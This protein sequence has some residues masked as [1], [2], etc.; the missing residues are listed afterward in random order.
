L[1]LRPGHLIDFRTV[2]WD[3][4]D[5][6]RWA[7]RYLG[8]DDDGIW[9]GAPAA[10]LRI[11]PNGVVERIERS[12]VRLLPSV[13][14]WCAMWNHL[15]DLDVYVD[16]CA[17]PEW[18]GGSCR[19]RDLQLDVVRY[20]DGTVRT[21]DEDEF[22]AARQRW[23]YSP[24]LVRQALE[25]TRRL[26]TALREATPPFNASPLRWLVITGGLEPAEFAGV[27]D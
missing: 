7:M 4:A 12:V 11:R 8:A 22:E 16:V 6:W 21:L 2:E 1:S 14:L 27:A 24:R 25:A 26:D 15:E 20:R 10:S 23:R 5:R 9:L 13:G 19:V 3:R 18:D 17:R